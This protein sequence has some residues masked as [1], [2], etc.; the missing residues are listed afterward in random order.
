MDSELV[1][2]PSIVVGPF[3]AV[4][5]AKYVLKSGP[6][7]EGKGGKGVRSFGQVRPDSTSR[8]LS[9][10]VNRPSSIQTLRR[11]YET[12]FGP[13]DTGEGGEGGEGTQTS[14]ITN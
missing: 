6:R 3:F 4:L 2:R 7:K 10:H 1:A 11:S 9:R 14:P 13:P 8:E 5:I 12:T